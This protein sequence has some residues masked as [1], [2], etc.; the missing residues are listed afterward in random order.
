M[1][2]VIQENSIGWQAKLM[3]PDQCKTC[4]TFLRGSDPWG[5]IRREIA[6]HL[7][8]AVLDTGVPKEHWNAAFPPFMQREFGLPPKMRMG[9]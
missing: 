1:A 3:A 2:Y 7:A 4:G 9:I 6:I 5:F 8:Q